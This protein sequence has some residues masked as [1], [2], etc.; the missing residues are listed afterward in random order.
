MFSGTPCIYS[1]FQEFTYYSELLQ[2][3]DNIDYNK[4]Y[5]R[6][7]LKCFFRLRFYLETIKG[8]EDQVF[9]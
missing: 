3:A 4:I 6:L 9:S 8:T 5:Q 7:L 1:S 2:L